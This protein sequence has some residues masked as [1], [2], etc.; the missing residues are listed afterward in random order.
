MAKVLRT[1]E[2]KAATQSALPEDSRSAGGNLGYAT[3]P[4]LAWGD[5]GEVA[6][7]EQLFRWLER[8][9][10]ETYQ[11]YIREKRSKA[12][13]SK[14]L[15]ISAVILLAVGGIV[16]V[17]ALLTDRAVD[18]EWGYIGLLVGAAAMLLD[19]GFGFSS[20]WSRY[21]MAA[22]Q[23]RRWLTKFQLEWA[24]VQADLIDRQ[25]KPDDVK[26]RLIILASF[27]QELGRLVESETALW[28][29]EFHNELRELRSSLPSTPR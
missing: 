2:D 6:S 27:A 29:S 4:Q 17:L 16:P 22:M 13:V 3:L 14:V 5:D 12:F 21:V 25:V 10:T 1:K 23:V 7:L 24:Q 20:S 18:P 26:A 8:Q 28:A 15:R 19:R 11:W 9:G